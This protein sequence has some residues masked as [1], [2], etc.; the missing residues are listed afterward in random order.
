[1]S[2]THVDIWASEVTAR[3]ATTNEVEIVSGPL[4]MRMPPDEA[5]ALASGLLIAAA[6]SEA[7]ELTREAA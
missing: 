2:H 4:H 5:R 6:A 3:V 7:N 1:M